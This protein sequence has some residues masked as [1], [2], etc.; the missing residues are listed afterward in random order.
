MK[1]YFS[2]H[3]LV[4]AI[5]FNTWDEAAEHCVDKIFSFSEQC[6]NDHILDV[7]NKVHT[8]TLDNS[9][10]LPF[11]L[12]NYSSYSQYTEYLKSLI[13]Y[14]IDYE[15]HTIDPHNGESFTTLQEVW[16]SKQIHQAMFLLASHCSIS[17]FNMLLEDPEY[18]KFVNVMMNKSILTST[19]IRKQNDYGPE[20]VSKFGMWGLV[21][22]LHDKIARLENLLS[23][24][25]KGHNNVNDETVYDTLLDIIGYSTVALLW[26]NDWFL[27]PLKR[28][29]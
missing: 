24:K 11:A 1:T 25:R 5:N 18:S 6:G 3:L 29:I 28:D 15:M 9:F 19:V 27:L 26:T 7:V 14:Y 21:V 17:L 2:E 13:D 8:V 23:P 10:S 22:R 20:N 4:D 16:D 12:L